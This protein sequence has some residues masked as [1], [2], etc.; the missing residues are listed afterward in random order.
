MN[1]D[2]LAQAPPTFVEAD[3]TRVR[4]RGFD[5]GTR[6]ETGPGLGR[7]GVVHTAHG[8]IRTPAFI[9][10]GTKA[11][12]KALIPEMV[13]ALGAQAVLANA[14]HL[15]LQPGA[16]IVDEAGGFGAF[17]NWSGPTYTDSGGF[18]VLSLGSGFKK[19]L[20]QEFSGTAD[21]DDP[22]LRMQA[23]K[24]SRAV[25]DEDSVTFKSHIDGTTHRFTPE[26]SMGIQ[27]KLGSD[28]MFAFD[29]L[30]SL[31]HPR[32]YQEESL[33][34][35]HRWARR[36][37]AE[38]RR[39]TEE[40]ADKPYQQLWGVVQGAQYQDLRRRAA[41][42]L[43]DM[44]EDGMRFDGF[45]VGGAL[46]KENLGRIVSW[47]CEELDE[48]RPR[49]LLGISEPDDLFAAVAAGADTFDCVNPSRVARNAA[50]YTPDGRFNITNSRFKRDF[51]PLVDGCG[52]YTCT[53]YTRAYVHHLFKAKEILSATLTTIHNEWFTVRLVDAIR[54]SIECG[55]FDDF[56]DDMVGRF[57]HSGR[58]GAR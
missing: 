33:D 29:E 25:I 32:D 24:A 47:V 58:T 34:R 13:Q 52:C 3:G 17:M 38:H 48:H 2:W 45:G 42:T 43:S 46:E 39:L 53:H 27:H 28:V 31:L 6:L 49:H 9:P 41:R 44:D 56:R 26:V 40:R 19:V 20:S 12:V 23:V 57:T 7:T 5:V 22:K 16:D 55:Q 1:T 35:T 15:Y 21:L 51:T 50:V 18:Q 14:Y 54:E 36:C 11:T 30:T 4:D 10:V 8:T 37:L